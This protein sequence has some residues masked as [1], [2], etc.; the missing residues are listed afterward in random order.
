MEPSQD[1][2]HLEILPEALAALWMHPHRGFGHQLN[3]ATWARRM[4]GSKVE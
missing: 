2:L 1:L 3:S 4:R